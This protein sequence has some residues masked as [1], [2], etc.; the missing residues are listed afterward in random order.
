MYGA[1]QLDI[2]L[3]D[4]TRAHFYIFSVNRRSSGKLWLIDR[5]IVM[6]TQI[7]SANENIIVL[8]NV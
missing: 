6:N 4:L 2:Y 5:P 1:I 3:L 8:Y 7:A